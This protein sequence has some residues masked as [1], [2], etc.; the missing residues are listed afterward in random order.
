M[1]AGPLGQLI[2]KD[3][4][5]LEVTLDEAPANWSTFAQFYV[6]LKVITIL[7]RFS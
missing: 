2:D 5:K 4:I 6:K 7:G 3:F 1:Y